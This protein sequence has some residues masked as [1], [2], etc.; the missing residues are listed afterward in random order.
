[1]NFLLVVDELL[2]FLLQFFFKKGVD[3]IGGN[4]KNTE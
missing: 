2:N 1:M 4:W 3:A